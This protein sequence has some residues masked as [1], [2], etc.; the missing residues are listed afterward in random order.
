MGRLDCAVIG[1]GRM[2]AFTSDDVRRYSPLCWLPLSHIEALRSLDS[3]YLRSVCDVNPNLLSQVREKYDVDQVYTDYKKLL[4]EICPNI[5]CIAT[6]TRE[7][8]E[9]VK[10]AI[11]AGVK[12]FHLEKPLCNSVEQLEQLEQLPW[13]LDAAWDE[14]DRREGRNRQHY[15]YGR[16]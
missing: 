14:G 10:A 6:R 11:E 3:V 15:Q 12:G 13:A 4:A 1:C 7:R 8:P 5:L 16:D 9:I 2:G